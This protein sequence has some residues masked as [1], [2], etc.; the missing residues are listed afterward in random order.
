[1]EEIIYK[2][3]KLKDFIFRYTLE[4]ETVKVKEYHR[5][6]QKYWAELFGNLQLSAIT[7]EEVQKAADG[8]A[9]EKKPKTVKNAL[10][11]L[12]YF[13]EMAI[14]KKYIRCNPAKGITVDEKQQEKKTVNAEVSEMAKKEIVKAAFHRDFPAA[15]LALAYALKI[16]ASEVCALKYSDIA[17][18]EKTILIQRTIRRVANLHTFEKKTILMEQ[19][20]KGKTVKLNALAKQVIQNIKTARKGKD[21]YIVCDENGHPYGPD[22]IMECLK[23]TAEDCGILKIKFSEFIRKS[24]P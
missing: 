14:Q 15:A 10:Y 13:L 2:K 9:E 4:N 5:L 22:V 23:K 18:D 16:T 6:Y 7:Q 17:K 19:N 20:K 12:S 1:M 11:A 24:S 21:E 3:I 8:Y